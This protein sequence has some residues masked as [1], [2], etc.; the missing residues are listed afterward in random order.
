VIG[1]FDFFLSSEQKQALAALTIIED[2]E[3]RQW[4]RRIVDL[5]SS[6][7]HERNLE[8]CFKA[9]ASKIRK[10]KSLV[11]K[12]ITSAY[13]S[14][15]WTNEGSPMLFVYCF[16][17]E[18][19]G[20]GVNEM[21]DGSRLMLF[22]NTVKMRLHQTAVIEILKMLKPSSPDYAKW[23]SELKVVHMLDFESLGWGK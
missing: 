9:L 2:N 6:E 5:T 23:L 1:P 15:K 17:A 11:E 10:N 12:G 22:A 21:S 3:R 4:G 8:H 18:S 20:Y 13:H 16:I 19:I 7:N 14:E